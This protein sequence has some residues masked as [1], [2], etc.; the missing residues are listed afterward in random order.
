ML[1]ISGLKSG[2][3]QIALSSTE[4]EYI[5]ML[6]AA[7]EV[8]FVKG[9][10]EFIGANLQ[11]PIVVRVDNVGAIYMANRESPTAR[12]KHVDT[13]RHFVCEYIED[14]ILKVVFGHRYQKADCIKGSLPSNL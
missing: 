4:A 13:R 3:V 7:T 12:T 11:Y 6:E 5:A 1:S 8:L 10:L 9:L 2:S 14:G